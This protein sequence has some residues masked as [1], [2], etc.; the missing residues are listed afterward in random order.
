MLRWNA[1]N[2]ILATDPAGN[3]KPDK[4]KALEKI[5]GISALLNAIALAV[6]AP[7]A[8]RS[9]YQDRGLLFL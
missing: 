3:Q 6:Q 4:A 8:Q 7:V 1:S 9:V 5:D 2:L